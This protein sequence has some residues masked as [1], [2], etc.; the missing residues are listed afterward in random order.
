MLKKMQIDKLFNRFNYTIVFNTGITILTGPNGFGKST[1]LNIIEA[2]SQKDLYFLF[3]VKFEKLVLWF[4]NFTLEIEKKDYDLILN[5]LI[6]KRD[7]YVGFIDNEIFRR[8]RPYLRRINDDTWFDRRSEQVY[9]RGELQDTFFYN[10]LDSDEFELDEDELSK[11]HLL[12]LEKIKNAV[13]EL[14]FIKDQRLIKKK[15]IRR[16]RF[17]ND[18]IDVIEQIPNKM[19]ALIS[20]ISNKYSDVANQLDSS[21]P[22]RLFETEIGISEAD[23]EKSI[24][25]M[26]QKF[27]KLGKYDIFEM[28]NISNVSFKEEH[29][30][31]LKIYFED[32]NLKYAVYK[33]FIHQLDMFTDMINNRLHFKSLRITRNE[34]I[35]LID[36]NENDESIKLSSLSSGEK[37]E[38][39]M[40]F[41]LIF[42]VSEGV[43]LL[44]DEPEISLHIAW[45]KIFMD[46]L[47]R[48]V[49]LKKI[50]VIVATHSPQIISNHWDKQIDL[51]E[52]YSN[53]FNKK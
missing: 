29:A 18:I 23:Y 4:D 25:D 30:K 7:I 15:R 40:F 6:F 37:Q 41:E 49:Q 46:D 9:K 32:F 48:I 21:Y 3:N 17:E 36:D 53:E 26:K 35:I 5:G 8:N 20:E 33:K 19:K 47:E 2:L 39:V 50:N 16:D 44:I 52:L 51:G 11:D 31:A 24:N 10:M 22:S 34:G 12:L 42:S 28:K 38:I 1:I 43:L 14:Y 27:E 45:Q 13:R